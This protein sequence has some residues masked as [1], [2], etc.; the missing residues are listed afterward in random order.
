MTVQYIFLAIGSRGDVDPLKWMGA[1]LRRRGAQ[2]VFVTLRPFDEEARALGLDTITAPS[3]LAFAL[4]S[5]RSGVVTALLGRSIGDW[6]G[7]RQ[8]FMA[9]TRWLFEVIRDRHLTGR[10]VVVGRSG[11]AAGRIARELFD[12]KLATV[13]HSPASMRSRYDSHRFGDP[14]R[15][16]TPRRVAQ[17]LVW[18][19]SDLYIGAQLLTDLNR[20][21]GELGLRP[22]SRLFDCWAPSPDLNLGL[23]PAWY[24]APQ[25]DW[26]RHARLAGFPFAPDVAPQ[27]PEPVMRF[28]DG[29]DPP[30][31]IT[32][33]AHEDR[34]G[35]L[36]RA[37]HRLTE[38]GPIR[39]IF[40]G[41][42]RPPDATTNPRLLYCSFAPLTPL[43]LQS[44]A[45]IH[46]G[47]IGTL[48]AGL[49]AGKPQLAA[50]IVGDQWDQAR[51]LVRLG[52]GAILRRGDLNE[53]L[54]PRLNALVT[55][56]RVADAC[57]E[58]RRRTVHSEGVREAVGW[59][60]RVAQAPL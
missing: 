5:R 51:R 15:D 52:C 39:A 55:D 57:E 44:R 25:P 22:V 29:G 30:L 9:R 50:P 32:Y 37:V 33:G 54:E 58:A 43:L 17:D 23:F 2:V 26:P 31:V 36:Q 59:L 41:R 13:H 20:F 3:E 7:M 53:G 6:S 18:R 12:L 47:G 14:G 16:R 34:G 48:A 45:I 10:C 56:A 8:I 38:K 46:H 21:R 42:E 11:L 28:L 4:Q 35:R 24:A 49:L 60:E 40:L 27:L 1:E 19:A